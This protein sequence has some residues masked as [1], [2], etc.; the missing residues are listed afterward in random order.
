MWS[1]KLNKA[2]I[3]GIKIL[4]EKKF[5]LRRQESAIIEKETK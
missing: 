5:H 3:N 2:I 4:K 1:Y